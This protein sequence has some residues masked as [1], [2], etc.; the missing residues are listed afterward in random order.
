M[1][2]SNSVSHTAI[3]QSRLSR[4]PERMFEPVDGASIVFFRI[5][6][7]VVILSHVWVAFERN[8]IELDYILPHFHFTWYWFQWVQPLPA[9][10][11]YLIFCV[12]GLA[13]AAMMM[14]LCYRVA[15]FVVC[16]LFTYEFLLDQS[17][18]LNH[19]YLTCLLAML[20]I[21][22]PAH[23]FLS[24]DALARPSMRSH[25]VPS[26]SL[27]I[28]RFQVAVPYFYSGITKLAPDWLRGQPM[29]MALE[30]RKH[31]LGPL[32]P[33]ASEPWLI[34][35]FNYGSLVF[36]LAIVPLLLW[37]RTR[38][39]AFL[40]AC[41]FHVT[42]HFMFDIGFFPWFMIA[43]TTL[44]FEPGWPRRILHA[45]RKTAS[46]PGHS[47]PGSTTKSPLPAGWSGLSKSRR[48]GIIGLGTY[49]L[50]QTVVPLRHYFYEGS[51][52]WSEEAH[53]FSWTLMLRSKQ[54]AVSYYATDPY[55]DQT[56]QVNLGQFLTRRQ[57]LD[58]GKYP[59]MV[60]QM[61]HFVRDQMYGHNSDVEIRVIDLI[62]LNGRK[63]QLL[64]D[65]R[66]NLA[67]EPLSWQTPSWIMPLQE[68][69]R[70][71]YWKLPVSE[72]RDHVD[73]SKYLRGTPLDPTVSDL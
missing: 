54:C 1:N 48:W 20:L 38:L 17:Y 9:V 35:M 41:L 15:A 47:S 23:H 44:F 70:D 45:A 56:S 12:M 66:V 19:Y 42:N 55:T 4:L 25:L 39:P 7:S 24:I 49:V 30:L 29:T 46:V 11:M 73:I 27:W 34:W 6:F 5:G 71:D 2:R 14:G 59:R 16:F 50:L 52:S 69:F 67:A 32:T 64:I 8:T 57:W 22:V 26:W 53:Q 13:A 21:F 33:Y 68:P 62:S 58:H 61:A 36:D 28:L 65:P 60:H 10:G 43:A 63:P 72:W 51:S 40:V 18:Y 3:N 37:R 31:R